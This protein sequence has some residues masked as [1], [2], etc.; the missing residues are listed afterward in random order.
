MQFRHQPTQIVQAIGWRLEE[1][2]GYV[3][4]WKILLKGKISIDGHQYVELLL[5]QGQQCT[6]L[7]SSPTPLRDRNHLMSLDFLG[8]A[9][10]DAFVQKILTV[11]M[12]EC[13]FSPLP[14]R[15]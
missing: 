2:H 14:T 11:R 3:E 12:P 6:V 8:Q 9:T 1:D 15:Q 4:L 10:V 7:G 13:E 5:G